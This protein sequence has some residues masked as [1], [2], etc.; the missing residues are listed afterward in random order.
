VNV[1]P[2]PGPERRRA[3]GLLVVL[4][5]VLAWLVW[6]RS[7]RPP[8]PAPSTAGAPATA[9]D[10][11]DPFVRAGLAD[12]TAP[13][14]AATPTEPSTRLPDAVRLAAL[15][16]STAPPDVGRNLFRFGTRPAPPPPPRPTQS[17]S[18]APASPPRPTGPPPV[19]LSLKGLATL[20]GDV[21]VA[22][23]RQSETGTVFQ[24]VEGQVVDGRYLVV[25]IGLQSAVVAYVDGSGQRTIPLGGG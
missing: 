5:A 12:A 22:T 14:A 13:A 8:E 15:D 16:L 7:T 18:T 24:A 2:P 3:V 11:R 20:P 23:L 1:L 4:L 10:P 9:N 6:P 21:R 17:V 19:P 25:R